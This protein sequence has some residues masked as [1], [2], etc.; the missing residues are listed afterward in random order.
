MKMHRFFA[1]QLAI[2]QRQ[3]DENQKDLPDKL[4]DFLKNWLIKHIMI[5]DQAYASF[6]QGKMKS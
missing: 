6:L 4:L 5:E 2:L 3:H 1:N